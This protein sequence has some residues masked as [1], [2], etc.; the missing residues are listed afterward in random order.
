MWDGAHNVKHEDRGEAVT[1]PFKWDLV[2]VEGT[3][4]FNLHQPHPEKHTRASLHTNCG[5][6]WALLR[7][8][9]SWQTV[10]RVSEP[11]GLKRRQ[12]QGCQIMNGK[13]LKSPVRVHVPCSTTKEGTLA[14]QKSQWR[15]RIHDRAG[16]CLARQI[17]KM[18]AKTD[19][20]RVAPQCSKRYKDKHGTDKIRVPRIDVVVT[21]PRKDGLQWLDVTIRRPTAVA[22]VEGATRLGGSAATQGEK[23]K[24]EEKKHV[25]RNEICSDTVKPT[26]FELGGRPGPQTISILQGMTTKLADNGSQ[27]AEASLGEDADKS[28]G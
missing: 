9:R 16:D 13:Q 5:R 11:L 17:R 8:L 3:R 6:K 12:R 4:F 21:V 2:N 25:K 7:K 22:N 28:R 14:C 20:E 1:G 26:S 23:E 24:N 10:D 18:G 27:K 15:T 19:L